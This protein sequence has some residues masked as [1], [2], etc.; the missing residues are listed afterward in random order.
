MEKSTPMDTS[1]VTEQI[2]G[3][4]TLDEAD[5]YVFEHYLS[6]ESIRLDWDALSPTDR[7]ALLRRSFQILEQLPFVSHKTCCA[8]PHSFPRCPFEEVP[9]AVKHAQIEQAIWW[10]DDDNRD[11][12]LA[13]NR[14]VSS[15]AIGNLNESFNSRRPHSNPLESMGVT[16]VAAARLLSQYIMGGYNIR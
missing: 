7:G 10:A 9:E 12:E 15:Y 5:A 4:V 14:G 1:E 13:R 16:S 11:Y 8:Q 6:T 2:I 3:Y